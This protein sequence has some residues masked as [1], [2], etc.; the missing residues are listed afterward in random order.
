MSA[1]DYAVDEAIIA[2]A[3]GAEVSSIIG[4]DIFS[5]ISKDEKTGTYD[6]T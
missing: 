5:Y 3:S 6:L 4:K 2:Y 1:Y